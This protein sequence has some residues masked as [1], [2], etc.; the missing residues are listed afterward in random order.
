MIDLHSHLLPGVDDG[1]RSVAQSVEVLR[2]MA[3]DGVTDVCLTPHVLASRADAG[4][5]AA[6]HAAFASLQAAAP[7]EIKLHRGGEV[8]LDRPVS[9]GVM[10]WTL[11]GGRYVL[12]EFPRMIAEEAVRNALRGVV[13]AGLVPVLAHPER[14]SSCSPAAA[15]RW[16][17]V[18]ARLQVD[19]TT[20]LSSQ[21]RG[22]R[23]RRLLTHGLA[24]LLAADNHGD[25]RFL[26]AA[27]DLLVSHRGAAQAELLTRRNPEAIL[28]SRE[29]ETV[30]PLEL[31]SGWLQRIRQLFAREQ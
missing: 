7:A 17:E 19:A 6:H 26:S 1:S 30:P 18:G 15:Y 11:G 2:Q 3:A 12:V 4:V 14:Y 8:M 22:Q 28:E 27:V 21:P 25:G 31:R 24:D 5:P 16:R 20:L 10:Q 29:L 13:A 9:A 23:A